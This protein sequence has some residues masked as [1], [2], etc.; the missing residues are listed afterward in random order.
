MRR[1]GNTNVALINEHASIEFTVPNLDQAKY[2]QTALQYTIKIEKMSSEEGN[3]AY[4][5]YERDSAGEYTVRVASG[6]NS[7]TYSPT[8]HPAT[9]QLPAG[10]FDKHFFRLIYKPS[11]ENRDQ[12]L[13]YISVEA[14]QVI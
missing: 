2:S 3:I 5:L 8:T 6:T 9:K 4:T 12:P 11:F 13:F 10:T 1:K 14:E 7:L